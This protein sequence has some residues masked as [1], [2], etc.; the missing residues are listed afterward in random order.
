MTTTATK[1]RTAKYPFPYSREFARRNISVDAYIAIV[2]L[3]LDR[4]AETMATGPAKKVVKRKLS[5]FETFRA[6][7]AYSGSIAPSVMARSLWED[8]YDRFLE[9]RG[10]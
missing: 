9:R 6:Q 2:T 1:T 3:E 5:K 4:L 10:S 8:R 7:A